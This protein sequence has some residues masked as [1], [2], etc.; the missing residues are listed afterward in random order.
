MFSKPNNKTR[1]CIVTT[2]DSSLHV[3]FPGFF[4]LLQEKNFDVTCISASGPWVNNVKSQMVRFI[5]VPMSRGFTP[6]R[7]LKCFLKLY[8]IFRKEDFDLIHYSTPK[9]SLLAGMAAKIS[10]CPAILY[11]MRGLGYQAFSGVKRSI[12][13]VCE[14][15]ACLCAHRIIVI[16]PSLKAEAVREKLISSDQGEVFGTGSSKG[17]DLERFKLDDERRE[18]AVIIKNELGIPE[19]SLVIGFAGRI[20]REK[21]IIELVKV[22]QLLKTDYPDV[23]LV[24]IGHKDQRNPLPEEIERSFRNNKNIHLLDFTD[25]L[26]EYMAI[27]DIVVLPSCRE[28]FGNS[29]IEGSAMSKPV[30]GMDVIGVRDAVLNRKTGILVKPY[31]LTSFRSALREL[32]DSPKLREQ[33]GRC[34]RSWVES[35][36]DQKVVWSNLLKLY[37]QMLS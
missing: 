6:F 15:I 20:T 14:K 21:G 24:L 31:D 19:Q 32:I 11:T 1:I 13:K 3:L 2:V 34:G 7:D 23:H 37:E 25:S 5:E 10:R 36:F 4:Q 33:M 27:M 18:K 17:V 35:A 29:L 12:G 16:S 8:C 9:A 30:V 28:G 22:C 26:A